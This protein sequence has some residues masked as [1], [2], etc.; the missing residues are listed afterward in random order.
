[1]HETRGQPDDVGLAQGGM[2]NTTSMWAITAMAIRALAVVG[3]WILWGAKTAIVW[4]RRR[5]PLLLLTS[6]AGLIR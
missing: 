6:T 3:L 2:G 4:A 1:M 5:C